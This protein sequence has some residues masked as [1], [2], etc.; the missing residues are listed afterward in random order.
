MLSN[1]R[2]SLHGSG[3]FGECDETFLRSITKLGVPFQ[4]PPKEEL[5]RKLNVLQQ[6]ANLRQTHESKQCHLLQTQWSSEQLWK[7][8]KAKQTMPSFD[9]REQASFTLPK[10]FQI[11]IC[12]LS[13]CDRSAKHPCTGI[14]AQR[15]ECFHFQ[16]TRGY[17][18]CAMIK[19]VLH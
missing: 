4:H 16:I 5:P 14:K 7:Q 12:S 19:R 8:R 9:N 10:S 15:Q 13:L 17:A 18:P 6:T 11:Q 3:D 1:G 2:Y